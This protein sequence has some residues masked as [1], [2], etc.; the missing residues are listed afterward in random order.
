MVTYADTI[1]EK[2]KKS[3]FVLNKFL[4]N[5]IKKTFSTIHLFFHLVQMVVFLVIDFFKIDKNMVL[6][7]IKK[8]TN[9]YKDNG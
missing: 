7:K 6:G 2:N 8:I 3:F 5:Y 4:K 9:D 1:I